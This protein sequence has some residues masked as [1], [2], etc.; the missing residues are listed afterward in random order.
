MGIEE[1]LLDRAEKEGIEKGIQ[2]G[3]QKGI[4]KGMSQKELEKNLAFTRNLL[5][6][7]DFSTSKVAQLV[8]VNEDFVL[9]VK[10][11]LNQ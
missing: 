11:E 4:E 8:G 10:S 2:K 5:S 6:S 1:F 7:T 3:I 9:K